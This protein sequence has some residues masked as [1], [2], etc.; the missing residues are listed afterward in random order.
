MNDGRA[1][2]ADAVDAVLI[3]SRALVAVAT[4][5]LGTAAEETT[6]AQYRSLVVLAS[7]GPQRLV[8]LA[9]TLGVAPST[10]GRMCERLIRKGL[11][12]RHRARAD[13]RAVLVSITAAGREVVDQATAR[14][15]ALIAEILTALP[16]EQQRDIAVALRAFAEA[17]GEVPDSDWP[18][19]PGEPPPGEP[20]LE[21]PPMKEPTVEEEGPAEG[22]GSRKSS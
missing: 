13:R 16:P 19:P 2:R 22:E 9:G 15:R 1:A 18:A 4:K 10:A 6:I 17:A 7:R 14:R 3:A 20:P 21:E 11:I 5:S 8:D 12:R